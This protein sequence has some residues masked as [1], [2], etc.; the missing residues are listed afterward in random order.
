M[1]PLL[2]L[3]SILFTILSVGVCAVCMCYSLFGRG[4]NYWDPKEKEKK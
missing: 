4:K 2:A 3:L 1:K